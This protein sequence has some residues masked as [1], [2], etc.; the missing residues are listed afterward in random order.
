MHMW[1]LWAVID[2]SG[3]ARSWTE[4]RAGDQA[5]LDRMARG[6]GDAVA[7]LYDRHARPIYSLALR[8]L[9][10]AGEAED[11]V[12][13][14]FSQAW[15]QAARY[16]A[17]RGAVAA[18][19]LTLT[20][21]RAIDRLRAKRARPAGVGDERTVGQVVDAGPPADSQV[22]SSEQVSRVRAALD[23]LPLLQRAA[24]ELAYFEGLTHAE[25][26]ARLEQPLGTVKT[27]IRLAMTKLRDVLAGTV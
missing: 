24:I 14:V 22:L 1:F 7:E 6:D 4:D 19:L 11:V 15:R 12:Q 23:E 2:R 3:S 5:A 13:E 16:S 21:S 8:I 20:R 9:G 27:R 17:S 18:W 25:I 26:A 10:D